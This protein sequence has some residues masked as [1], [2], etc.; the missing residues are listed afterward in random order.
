M[1]LNF[2]KMMFSFH[3]F[4]SAAHYGLV[5]GLSK[6]Y[7]DYFFSIKDEEFGARLFCLPTTLLARHFVY[8]PHCLPFVLSPVI[9]STF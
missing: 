1:I 4:I 2:F 5:Q 8:Q 9:L 6:Y 3:Y 7:V